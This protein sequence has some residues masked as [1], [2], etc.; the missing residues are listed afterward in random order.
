MADFY[1]G[2]GKLATQET[3]NR[4]MGD[5]SS[6]AMVASL[7]ELARAMRFELPS[8]LDELELLAD[9]QDSLAISSRELVDGKRANLKVKHVRWIASSRNEHDSK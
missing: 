6:V 2:S 4:K 5:V 3:F 8:R 9:G 7:V 1:R